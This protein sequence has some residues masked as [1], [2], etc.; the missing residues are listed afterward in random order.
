MIY[1]NKYSKYKNKYLN[2]KNQF[3]G[4]GTNI[5]NIS[6]T[7]IS[8]NKI[9]VSLDLNLAKYSLYLNYIMCR[10]LGLN[11]KQVRLHFFK[12]VSK[13]KSIE[14]IDGEDIDEN[15]QIEYTISRL[16]L[17]YSYGKVFTILKNDETLV[18][19]HNIQEGDNEQHNPYEQQ[20]EWNYLI[21]LNVVNK[22]LI[23][24]NILA[25][26]VE[27]IF[28]SRYLC[29]GIKN[30]KKI[31]MWGPDV[32]R[33]IYELINSKKDKLLI[34]NVYS[35][36]DQSYAILYKNGSVI[37]W[38]RHNPP[39][40]LVDVKILCCN[41]NAF[42]VATKSGDLIAW[43]H[44]SKGGVIPNSDLF[45]TCKKRKLSCDI[46]KIVGS[47]N[48]QGF[49]VLKS[50]GTVVTWGRDLSGAPINLPS[51]PLKSIPD[52]IRNITP[53]IDAFIG[54]STIGNIYGWGPYGT[55]PEK[56]K[57]GVKQV[58]ANE[59]YFI[60]I[61][62]DNS[63][64]GWRYGP[65]S[66]GET[67]PE[68]I[69]IPNTIHIKKIITT[70]K[71]FAVLKQDGSVLTGGDKEYGGISDNIQTQLVSVF[72]IY[73]TDYAFAALKY[74]GSVVTW[75][76][77]ENGGDMGIKQTNLQSNVHTVDS[78]SNAFIAVKKDG[79]IILWGSGF[80]NFN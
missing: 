75:G 6:F 15:T 31:F 68:T 35:I 70:K 26:D 41:G 73:S 8:G 44:P 47:N 33:D 54:L 52:S 1:E 71:A 14:L 56:C 25:N 20:F 30:D 45:F 51:W 29:L 27:K 22:L 64:C 58:I 2:L 24:N 34:E 21:P 78:T 49:A 10:H 50:D 63:I 60:T 69:L 19:L 5:K 32:P 18:L 13:E 74:D 17:V 9:L 72:D 59:L 77:P 62:T 79:S 43:G 36:N 57:S 66:Y 65:M 11:W 48:G 76:N 16:H 28:I 53:G 7:S 61:K 42:V 39:K 67:S 23:T 80:D 38:G 4:T 46:I 40:P 55:I 3:A 12:I 37:T